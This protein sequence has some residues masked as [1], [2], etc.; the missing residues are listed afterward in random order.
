MIKITTSTPD[1]ESDFEIVIRIS[2]GAGEAC[3]IR[4]ALEWSIVDRRE[5]SGSDNKPLLD[6]YWDGKTDAAYRIGHS[7][8]IL[9]Q[10]R[11][12]LQES[13]WG[14]KPE[15]TRAKQIRRAKLLV[16][17]ALWIAQNTLSTLASE[18]VMRSLA[19]G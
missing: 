8:D 7:S 5:A 17:R 14:A 4:S 3:E 15:S 19:D 1:R 10:T 13:L 12:A 18:H 6:T 9:L 16:E 2:I 11:E